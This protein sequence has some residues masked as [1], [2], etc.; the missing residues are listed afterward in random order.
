MNQGYRYLSI[1]LLSA[2]LGTPLA[3]ARPVVTTPVV[4]MQDHDDRD[5]DR[6]RD[7]RRVYDPYHKDYH[8][9]D[10]R[11]DSVYRHWL[12]TRHVAYRDFDRLQRSQQRAYWNWRHEHEEH[13][14][15]EHHD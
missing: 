11:E 2:A 13:E 1:F 10:D 6:D 9:W 3:S 4:A 15:H 8:T 14:E 12:E 7:N 5:H